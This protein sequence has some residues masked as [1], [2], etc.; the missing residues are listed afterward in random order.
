[1]LNFFENKGRIKSK[2]VF[3]GILKHFSVRSDLLKYFRSHFRKLSFSLRLSLFALIGNALGEI[4]KGRVK[5]LLRIHSL[6]F[7]GLSKVE[8]VNEVRCCFTLFVGGCN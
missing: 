2:K 8:A 5:N 1:L 3:L 4:L 7:V 6:F